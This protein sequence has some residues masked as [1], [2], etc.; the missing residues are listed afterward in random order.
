MVK[1]NSQNGNQS[2][3]WPDGVHPCVL[4]IET[5]EMLENALEV[6]IRCNT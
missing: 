3:G 5:T 6:W 4:V 2:V 1:N